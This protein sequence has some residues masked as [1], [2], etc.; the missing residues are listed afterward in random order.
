MHNA[1]A[2]NLQDWGFGDL[3]VMNSPT[4]GSRGLNG[5][6]TPRLDRMAAEGTLFTDF[7]TMGAEC[8]PSRASFMTGRSPSDKAVRIH[9]VIGDHAM[10]QAKGCAD[11]LDPNTPT[12]TS[13]L[14]GVSGTGKTSI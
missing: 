4:G 14:R 8:S 12:V 10:N 6:Q 2:L 11:F 3:G 13:M 1:P 5:P 7:H 9:L